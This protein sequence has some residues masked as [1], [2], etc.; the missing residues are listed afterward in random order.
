MSNNGEKDKGKGKAKETRRSPPPGPNAEYEPPRSQ[1]SKTGISSPSASQ[2][3]KGGTSRRRPMKP[4]E[5]VESAEATQ[6]RE[7]H[8]KE[9]ANTKK[10]VIYQEKKLGGGSKDLC[11]QFTTKKWSALGP[12]NG[13]GENQTGDL[14]ALVVAPV[15]LLDNWKEEID[16]WGDSLLDPIYIIGSEDLDKKVEKIK[17]WAENGTLLLVGYENLLKLVNLHETIQ[18]TLEKLNMDML[19]NRTASSTKKRSVDSIALEIQQLEIKLSLTIDLTRLL[20]NTPK[21][22]VADEAHKIKNEKSQIANLFQRFQTNSRIA[23]TGSPLSNNL[24]DYYNIMRWV[25]SSYLGDLPTFRKKYQKRI[26]DGL[27]A[28]STTEEVYRGKVMQ[29]ALVKLLE[30]KMHRCGIGSIKDQLPPKTEFLITLPL[31]G[32]QRDIYSS[33]IEKV[34]FYISFVKGY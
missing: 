28:D 17:K 14:R 6:R 22:V 23:M 31:T 26:E 27:Y 7:K 30:M 18:R 16:K 10:R 21:I 32:L 2:E 3:T 33:Y 11:R 34:G 4:P 13:D 25:D 20:L 12:Y 1:R 8:L 9:V 19:L 5:I 29:S 15:G 24:E